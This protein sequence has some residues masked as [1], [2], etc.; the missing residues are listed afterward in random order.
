ML[1]HQR[2]SGGHKKNPQ[3]VYSLVGYTSD[4]YTGRK[5]PASTPRHTTELHW[6]WLDETLAPPPWRDETLGILGGGVL[7]L[8]CTWETWT[9]RASVGCGRSSPKP[10]PFFPLR[11]LQA[12][13]LRQWR[14]PPPSHPGGLPGFSAFESRSEALPF[15]SKWLFQSGFG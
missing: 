9:V 13:P 4:N 12:P 2:H 7:I 15:L 5:K 11:P 3:G 1:S 8:F 10:L 14:V 6:T